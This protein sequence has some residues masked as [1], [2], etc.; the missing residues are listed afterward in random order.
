M[1]YDIHGDKKDLPKLASFARAAVASRSLGGITEVR[2]GK[3]KV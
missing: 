3:C 2:R 1:N